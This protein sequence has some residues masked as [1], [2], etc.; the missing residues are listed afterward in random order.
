MTVPSFIFIGAPRTGSTSLYYY[1]KQ[2]PQIFMSTPK[3][4]RFFI[5]ENGKSDFPW[6]EGLESI[7]TWAAYQS[8]FSRESTDNRAVGEAS[9]LYLYSPFSAQRIKKYLPSIKL[10][11]MLRHP[12]ERAYSHHCLRLNLAL[13]D[14][15]DFEQVMRADQGQMAGGQS[16]FPYRQIGLYY[17][18]LQRYFAQFDQDQIRV[19]LYDDYQTNPQAVIQKIFRFLEVDP[20]FSPDRT[21]RYN[22]FDGIPKNQTWQ[23]LIFGQNC[24]K[25]WIRRMVPA[26]LRW[27]IREKLKSVNVRAPTPLSPQLRR[28]LIGFYRAD[29]LQLQ[30]LLHRDLSYWLQ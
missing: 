16:G 2:H 1:L 12:V 4:P 20:S 8:L 28:E 13:E 25:G 17:A 21:R 9:V 24:V 3:E 29:I 30:E 26:G 10:I 15:F 22:T 19:F 27:V 18:Q 5:Y 14:Q 6:L 7:T 11:A 23:G